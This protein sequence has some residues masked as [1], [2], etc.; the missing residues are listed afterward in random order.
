MGEARRAWHARFGSDE[1]FV[2]FFHQLRG[3]MTRSLLFPI[4]ALLSAASSAHAQNPVKVDPKHYKV[5]YEDE[6]VRVLRLN[7]GPRE[8]SVMH[9]HPIGTCAIFL[10]EFHGRDTTEDKKVTS[11]NYKAGDVVC[12]PVKPGVARHLPENASDMPHELIVV[13]RKQPKKP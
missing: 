3:H 2:Q 7:F 1:V 13:E 11:N 6:T 4:V 8:K 12:E 5:V 10:T 9:E